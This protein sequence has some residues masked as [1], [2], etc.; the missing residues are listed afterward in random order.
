LDDTAARLGDRHGHVVHGD[1]RGEFEPEE[2]NMD[3]DGRG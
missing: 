2:G 1:L 3:V